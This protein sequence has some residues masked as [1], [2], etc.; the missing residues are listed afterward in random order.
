MFPRNPKTPEKRPENLEAY[1]STQASAYERT[2]D[3]AIC[4]LRAAMAISHGIS[5]VRGWHHDKQTGEVLPSDVPRYIALMH[6]ELSEMLEADRKSLMD[7]HLP[8]MA[9]IEVE[10]A[11][12]LIRALDTAAK[13]NIDLPT[14]F[15]AKCQFNLGREDHSDE[16]RSGANGKLY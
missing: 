10:L 14:A 11:D 9:G 15:Y 12:L 7:D 6:S 8:S 13:L 3:E 4:G 5:C 16:A 1:L 2:M